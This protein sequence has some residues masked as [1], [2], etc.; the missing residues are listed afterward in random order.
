MSEVSGGAGWW[1]ASDGRWYPPELHPSRQFPSL[2]TDPFAWG[3]VPDLTQPP[4]TAAKRSVEVPAGAAGGGGSLRHIAA[5]FWLTT[6]AVILLL[7]IGAGTGLAFGLSTSPTLASSQSP[8]GSSGPG[9]VPTTVGAPPVASGPST[10]TSTPEETTTIPPTT[11]PTSPS[12]HAAPIA[13][14]PAP[15][16]GSLVTPQ[17][18]QAVV[19]S[20]WDTFTDAFAEDDI[21]TVQELTTPSAYQL[22][23]GAFACGCPPW[24]PQFSEVSF[25]A[26]PQ[27]SYPISFWAE[28]EG[29]D[30]DGESMTKEVV[31]TQA[32]AGAPWLVSDF[33]A[34]YNG[35]PVL[36]T[37]TNDADAPVLVTTPITTVANAFAQYIQTVDT[38]GNTT[39]PS[40][41]VAGQ[42]IEE[43]ITNQQWTLDQQNGWKAAWTHTVDG[44]SSAFA[45]PAYPGNVLAC[46]AM[47]F[48]NVTTSIKGTAIVQPADQNVF[49]RLLAPGSYSSVTTT[50]VADLCFLEYPD[51]TARLLTNYAGDTSVTGTP[52]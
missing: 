25:S 38:T 31:F 17:V 29:Q 14:P 2:T 46:F 41:I 43:S 36:G 34:Y 6:S 9:R 35:A 42:Y 51:G 32:S 44:T 39:Y 13:P 33:G 10:I 21:A 23:T 3:P 8:T 19:N 24:P 26:P 27:T 15:A 49:P 7:L 30:Y 5:R 45:I 18:E 40:G 48:Q 4:A 11:P 47:G 16:T 52:S 22:V 1:I 28:F 50:G 37:N 20:T 12:T